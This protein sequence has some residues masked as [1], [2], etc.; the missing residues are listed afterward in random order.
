[1]ETKSNSVLVTTAITSDYILTEARNALYTD[2][3]S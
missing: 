2:N 1:M 3:P